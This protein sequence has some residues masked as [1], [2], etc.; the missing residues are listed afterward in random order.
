MEI[1]NLSFID[2]VHFLARRAGL[3]VPESEQDPQHSRRERM[4]ALNRDAARFFHQCL[5]AAG[6][7][8]RPGL[9]RP[10]GR[11]PPRW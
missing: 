1:E 11:S 3:Q 9:H 7:Q 4:L 5:K 8:P 6:G 2:A 10:S